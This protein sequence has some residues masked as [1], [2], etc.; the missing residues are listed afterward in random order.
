MKLQKSEPAADST[1]TTA[2]NTIQIWFSEAPDTKVSKV[3]LAGPK[4]P[5]KVMGLHAMD[6]SLMVMIDGTIADGA[7]VVTWQS[8]GD[9]GHLQKGDFKFTFKAAK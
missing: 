8:A 2:P 1:V 9:D 4:G 3:E 5:I 7:Y 6:K